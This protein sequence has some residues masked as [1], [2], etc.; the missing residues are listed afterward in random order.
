MEPEFD[1]AADLDDVASHVGP[2]AGEY[3]TQ[4]PDSTELGQDCGASLGAGTSGHGEGRLSLE[5]QEVN[6]GGVRWETPHRPPPG[7]TVVELGRLRSDEE[8]MARFFHTDPETGRFVGRFM[9]PA[10]NEASHGVNTR[11]WRTIA[12]SDGQTVVLQAR[13]AGGGQEVIG[14]LYGG[15]RARTVARASVACAA[16]LPPSLR[17]CACARDTVRSGACAHGRHGRWL[18]RRW[19]PDTAYLGAAG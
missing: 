4:A 5:E 11:G 9:S 3:A 8:F 14:V 2:F 1:G 10:E 17:A 15:T 19:A 18:V 16:C 7:C 6:E 13:K 12:A